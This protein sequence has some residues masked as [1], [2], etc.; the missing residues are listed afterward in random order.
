MTFECYELVSKLGGISDDFKAQMG[1]TNLMRL[2][3][4]IRNSPAARIHA[5]IYDADIASLE[6]RMFQLLPEFPEVGSERKR[7]VKWLWKQLNRR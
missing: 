7:M 4:I 3:R 1:F 6:K 2:L 5:G